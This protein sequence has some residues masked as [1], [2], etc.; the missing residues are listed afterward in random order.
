MVN[1]SKDGEFSVASFVKAR[2]NNSSFPVY[3][4]YLWK[5]KAP[6]RVLVLVG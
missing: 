2:S 5:S 6:S 3:I 1:S 4:N